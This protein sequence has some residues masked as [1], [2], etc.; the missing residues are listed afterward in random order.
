MSRYGVHIEVSIRGR[1]R[2]E[3]RTRSATNH[4]GRKSVRDMS[5]H[6]HASSN[7]QDPGISVDEFFFLGGGV[8]YRYKGDDGKAYGSYLSSVLTAQSLVL[9]KQKLVTNTWGGGGITILLSKHSRVSVTCAHWAVFCPIL[10]T[11]YSVYTRIVVD[12]Y[13]S[14]SLFFGFFFF[15]V[16]FCFRVPCVYYPIWVK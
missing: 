11:E 10:R 2:G 15:V 1:G 7:F 16:F 6:T 3:K 9:D 13:L 12:F 4:I 5:T 14:L 8:V